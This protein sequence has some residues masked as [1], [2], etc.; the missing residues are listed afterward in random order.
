MPRIKTPDLPPGPLA[1]FFAALQ[2]MHL[3]AGEPSTR[4]IARLSD[5]LSHDTVHRV[6]TA[7]SLPK[8][9]NVETIVTALNGDVDQMRALWLAARVAE[10]GD[11]VPPAPAVVPDEVRPEK[12]HV[13]RGAAKILVVDDHPLF[14]FGLTQFLSALG[15]EVRE[16]ADGEESVRVAA[17]FQPALVLM[18][19]NMP[20][21]SGIDATAVLRDEHP[22]ARVVMLTMFEDAEKVRRSLRAGASGYLVKGMDLADLRA[23]VARALAGEPVFTSDLAKAVMMGYESSEPPG[24]AMPRLTFREREALRHMA[25]GMPDRMIAQELGVSR[26]TVA[27]LWSV[28]YKKLG[29]PNRA[30]AVALA[31]R[32]GLIGDVPERR[33]DLV[34][35]LR[36]LRPRP[37]R[38]PGSLVSALAGIR[39]DDGLDTALD[40]VRSWVLDTA[41]RLPAPHGLMALTDLGYNDRT[42]LSTSGRIAWLA[43][44]L[45]LP[46]STVERQLSQSLV[47]LAE[48][49]LRGSS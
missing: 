4:E 15:Y 23:N 13:T 43:S 28:V 22:D 36:M 17:E 30:S 47:M 38:R 19:I 44:N 7:P 3:Q 41:E 24:N 40:K 14:R 16:A 6:L 10:D 39:S 46:E 49:A 34:R 31:V 1:D 11:A 5:A 21:M 12:P 27:N 45:D 25:D 18:D 48:E 26:K 35:E 2:W 37:E 9:R 42:P 29:V 32:T 8:W 20:R 33:A